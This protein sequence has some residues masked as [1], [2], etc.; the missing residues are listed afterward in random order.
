MG[1]A[2][3]YADNTASTGKVKLPSAEDALYV[4]KQCVNCRKF[5]REVDNN[6][7][8]GSSSTSQKPICFFHR[9]NTCCTYL[10]LAS[11]DRNIIPEKQ[12]GCIHALRHVEDAGYSA[13]IAKF[14]IHTDTLQVMK[15]VHERRGVGLVNP[16]DAADDVQIVD[17]AFIVHRVALTDTLMGISLYYNVKV[18]DIQRANKLISH[19]IYHKKTLLIPRPD[20]PI[21]PR[22]APAESAEHAKVRRQKQIKLFCQ[23]TSCDREE[24]KYYMEACDYHI[25][26]A[27]KEWKTDGEWA[28]NNENAPIN[29]S[30]TT[31]YH[32]KKVSS[33]GYHKRRSCC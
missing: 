33:A 1:F 9:S 14:P 17:D 10:D 7:S 5:Y 18:P 16:E 3:A 19:Q 13:I 6:A 11:D 2:E 12:R 25:D 32:H 20:V 28:K 23:M 4:Q 30:S 29:K 26:K 21:K 24:A 22:E 8:E 27:I 15:Q 31:T